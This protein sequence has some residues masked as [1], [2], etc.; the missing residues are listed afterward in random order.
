MPCHA[1]SLLDEFE[2]PDMN[3]KIHHPIRIAWAKIEEFKEKTTKD[4]TLQ[5]LS[6]Q[7]IQGRP[8]SVKKI[9]PT[10]NLY[11]SLRDD[12]SIE[13]RPIFLGS[14]VTIPK[15]M[16]GNI[17]QHIHRGY[18]GVEKCRVQAK[19]CVYSVIIIPSSPSVSKDNGLCWRGQFTAEQWL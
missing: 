13:D 7:V 14:H 16:G 1:L 11:L 18:F 2:V 3:V 17:L 9:D 5:L 6:H 4:E 8:D 19:S 10:V 12:K 15:C